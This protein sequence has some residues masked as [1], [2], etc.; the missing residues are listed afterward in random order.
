MRRINKIIFT[1][2]LIIICINK[3][4]AASGS[5]TDIWSSGSSGSGGSPSTPPNPGGID[6]RGSTGFRPYSTDGKKYIC[7][8][9]H[10]I[11]NYTSLEINAYDINETSLIPHSLKTN[12][13]FKAGTWV[14]INAT[15]TKSADWS[16]NNFLYFELKKKYS[17][18]YY[19]EGSSRTVHTSSCYENGVN[20]QAYLNTYGS[21]Y[22]ANKYRTI[23]CTGRTATG[24]TYN[25]K[26]CALRYVISEVDKWVQQPGTVSTTKVLTTSDCPK[27]ETTGLYADQVRVDQDNIEEAVSE[28]KECKIQA[29]DDIEKAAIRRVSFASNQ[30]EYEKT[31]KSGKS[32]KETIDAT[33]KYNEIQGI[34]DKEREAEKNIG[35]VWQEYEYTPN[36]V[37]MNMLTSNVTYNGECHLDSNTKEIPNGTVV[38]RNIKDPITGNYGKTMSYWHYFIPLDAR[39]GYENIITL[40]KNSTEPTLTKNQCF[41][42]MEQHPDDYMDYIKPETGTFVGDYSKGENKS[43]DIKTVKKENGC[44]VAIVLK[45]ETTQEFYKEQTKSGYASLKGYGM[46]FR[47]ID[48][49]NPF[50]NGL[51]KESYWYGLYNSGKVNGKVLT[52]SFGNKSTYVANITNSA[53]NAIRKYNNNT[54][55]TKWV[56]DNVVRN[57]MNA[58]GTSDFIRINNDTKNIFNKIASTGSFYKL[59]CGPTNKDWSWCKS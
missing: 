47:Q 59:G 19:R 24:N 31:N 37:C 45:F 16:I 57:G 52:T 43:S 42:G 10:K 38:D 13:L 33:P 4:Y 56:R 12:K 11:I 34:R 41:S 49:N 46:F 48:I 50:P 53:A 5:F 32:S 51:T 9:K 30:L 15:E 2:L 40:T 27:D 7:Y 18:H 54:P 1:V 29:I 3:I 26:K 55:Y 17:C 35:K 58:N 22:G 25:G 14:G 44:Y 6:G 8:Y 28:I 39:S 20:C 36:R 23:D 21:T